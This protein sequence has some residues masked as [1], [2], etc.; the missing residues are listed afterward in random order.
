MIQFLARPS[1]KSEELGFQISEVITFTKKL[2]HNIFLKPKS[3]IQDHE[4]VNI[5]PTVL[6]TDYWAGDSNK[7]F[8]PNINKNPSQKAAKM[9]NLCS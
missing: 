2:L 6:S 8:H 1:S 3:S 5:L 7:Y 4:I 9:E